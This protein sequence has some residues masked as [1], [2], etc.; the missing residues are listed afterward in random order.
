MTDALPYSRRAKLPDWGTI[1][2]SRGLT[3]AATAAGLIGWLYYDQIVRMSKI[4]RENLDWSHGFLILPFSLYLVHV[5]RG[6]LARVPARPSWAGLPVLLAGIAGYFYAVW[7]KIGYPQPLTMIPVIAGVVLLLAGPTVLARCA[8]PI[9]YLVLAMPPSDRLYKLITQ[10]MQQGAAT[11]AEFV[12][13][14]LPGVVPVRSGINL[15]V[16]DAVTGALRASFTVAGAC[17]GM[18]SLLA[19]LALGLAMAY[20]TPRPMWQRFAMAVLVLPVALFCNAIRVVITGILLTYKLADFAS[21]TPHTL[22]GI[23]TFVLGMFIYSAL[24]YIMDN[25]F[26]DDPDAIADKAHGSGA[27]A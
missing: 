1:L 11:V 5:R 17:S 10:P 8:F 24:L 19:F 7:A 27:A 12:L 25:F 4:W 16:F 22:L 6:E 14:L 9:G 18:R 2:G 13:N 23:G 21:G 26:V 15:E 20:F 3:Q